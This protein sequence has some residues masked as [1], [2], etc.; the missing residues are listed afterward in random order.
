[1]SLGP[2]E[3]RVCSGGERGPGGG[4]EHKS[5]QAGPSEGRGGHAG[6]RE[7]GPRSAQANRASRPG[8]HTN[9]AISFRA[10]FNYGQKILQVKQQTQKKK[11]NQDAKHDY[12]Y[13]LQILL[14]VSKSEN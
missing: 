11:K 1:M 12:K 3:S 7:Q 13:F 5:G 10:N 6:G 9:C 14:N 2:A 8:S 4:G